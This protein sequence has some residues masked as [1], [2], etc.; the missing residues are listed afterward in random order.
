MVLVLHLGQVAPVLLRGLGLVL[1]LRL[2]GGETPKANGVES[3]RTGGMKPRKVPPHLHLRVRHTVLLEEGLRVA[4]APDFHD[5]QLV[6]RPL[7]QVAR[8]DVRVSSSVG[9]TGGTVAGTPKSGNKR[10]AV[11]TVAART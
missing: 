6:C 10:R 3:I 9:Q 5:F 8:P 4:V 11:V 2:R 7:V 1:L